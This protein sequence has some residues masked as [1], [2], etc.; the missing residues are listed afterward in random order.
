MTLDAFCKLKS[1]YP[2]MVVWRNTNPERLGGS[3]IMGA[4]IDRKGVEGN[5]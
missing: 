2:E 5:K 1:V 3:K 4:A